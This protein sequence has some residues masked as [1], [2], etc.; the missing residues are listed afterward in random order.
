MAQGGR[1]EG[2]GRKACPSSEKRMTFSCC[3]TPQTM[4]IVRKA[5]AEGIKIGNEIDAFFHHF[6][7]DCGWIEEDE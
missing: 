2:S 5:R 1:R 7:V 4:E 3:V 6:A